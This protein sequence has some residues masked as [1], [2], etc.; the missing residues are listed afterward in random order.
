LYMQAL[1][2]MRTQI[3]SV[4]QPQEHLASTLFPVDAHRILYT[5]SAVA[6]MLLVASLRS[7]QKLAL[8]TDNPPGHLASASVL[9][10]AHDG[11]Q[12]STMRIPTPEHLSSDAARA[13]CKVPRLWTALTRTRRAS[14]V[15]LAGIIKAATK[16]SGRHAPSAVSAKVS[17]R[18]CPS[19]LS[20]RPSEGNLEEGSAGVHNLG[21]L[22]HRLGSESVEGRATPLRVGGSRLHLSSK[23]E[24]VRVPSGIAAG[25]ES[26]KREGTAT[27][28]SDERSRRLA[29]LLVQMGRLCEQS[30]A[31]SEDELSG[32]R[33]QV[34]ASGAAAESVVSWLHNG[35]LS[36]IPRLREKASQD[37]V[38]AKVRG[39]ERRRLLNSCKHFVTLWNEVRLSAHT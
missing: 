35:P 14:S 8:L 18:V 30:K 34:L 5:P 38:L 6:Y 32:Q 9:E 16:K 21:V 26:I 4:L 1:N 25:H 33:G 23:H 11:G 19:E 13:E 29:A 36:E 17:G 22:G 2:S 39:E 31:C 12:Y 7:H 24:S 27:A 3:L 37:G 28:G 10:N 15:S 20:S